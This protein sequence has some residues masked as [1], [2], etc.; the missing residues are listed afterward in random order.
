MISKALV[1]Y[2]ILALSKHDLKPFSKIEKCSS[3]FCRLLFFSKIAPGGPNNPMKLMFF[4]KIASGGPNNPMKL[5]FFSKIAPGGPNTSWSLSFIFK[6]FHQNVKIGIVYTSEGRI[7]HE[8]YLLFSK[9]STK[10]SKSKLF[11]LLTPWNLQFF[12]K[13]SPKGS[14]HH[15][16]YIIFHKKKNL[17][18]TLKIS[19]ILPEGQYTPWNLN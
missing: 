2:Y 4:S 1:A 17:I 7:N 18:K 8:T 19:K 13:F 10:M 15:E 12:Q 9:N 16:T 6:I 14:I 5:M 3:W 11:T